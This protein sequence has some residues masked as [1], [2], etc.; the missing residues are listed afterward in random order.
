MKEMTPQDLRDRLEAGD[1]IAVMDI[2]ESDEFADWHIHGSINVPMYNAIASGRHDVVNASIGDVPKDKT[3]VAVCRMGNTSRVAA[4]VLGEMG[5]DA[6]SLVGGMRGWSSAWTEAKVPLKSGKTL[7]Q[8]RRNGK[9]C[10]SYIFGSNGECGVVDPSVNEKVYLQLAKREGFK[11]TH[12]LETHVHADHISRAREL[13][14]LADA[15]LCLPTNDRVSFDYTKIDDGSKLDVGG[16]KVTVVATPGHTGESVCFDLDGEALLSG[17]T[18]FL[19]AIGRPDLEKGDE[20]AAEGA[21]KLYASLHDKVLKLS[22]DMIVAPGHTSEPIGFDG[23]P[24]VDTLAAIT[25]RVQLLKADKDSFVKQIVD[26]I[27]AKPPNFQMVIAINE[28]KS[29]LGW[30]DPLELEAGP[31]RCAVKGD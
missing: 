14:E 3:V 22:G 5:Y 7:I 31:N 18:I 19:E 29:A 9:G 16:F 12:V 17:D 1:A 27:G 10:F 30:L 11:I 13:A 4:Q 20:G 21:R 8:V 26:G 25:P 23:K 28:G 2:R 6:Y 24:L 15:A